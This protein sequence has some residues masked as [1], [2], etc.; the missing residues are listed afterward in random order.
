MIGSRKSRRT[1]SLRARVTVLLAT[2]VSLAVGGA[3]TVIDMR[4]DADMQQR[5]DSALLA[6]AQALT[7]LVRHDGRKVDVNADN[8]QTFTFPGNSSTHWYSL[9]CGDAVVART[10]Q[11]PPPLHAG[12]TPRFADARLTDGRRLRVVVLRFQPD[13]DAT[14]G[15][16]TA[17]PACVLRYGLDRKMLDEILYQ[18]D[19]ILV[20]SLLGACLVVLLATPW[21]VRRGLQPL[22]SLDAAMA[23]IG[24]DAPGKRLPDSTTSELDPLVARFNEVL[25]RMDA[26][27]TRERRFASGLAHEFRT[28]LAELRMLV[29][30]EQA[31]PSGRDVGSVLGEVGNIGAE[32][33]ATVTALLRLTRIES[34]LEQPRFEDTDPAMLL[35]R[36]IER[37]RE[38]AH[39]REVS[40]VIETA[41]GPPTRIATDPTLLDIVLDNLL[42]NAT[43]YAPANT[44][45]RV[46]VSSGAVTMSNAAPTLS[47]HDID[48]FGRRFWRK[49]SDSAGHAGL[50]LALAVAAAH[51]LKMSVAFALDNGVLRATLRWQPPDGAAHA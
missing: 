10:A 47:A 28:R 37:Q 40:I 45:I 17:A 30:V 42:G 16:D 38:P 26:G 34:G 24:P 6:R 19:M 51:V 2:A 1:F 32:L 29:D 14:P 31:H 49:D 3:A 4:A 15:P 27:L 44:Q 25:A 5:F 39:R 22:T 46:R 9:N 43:A 20:G 21:L 23:G 41:D 35:D 48:Q 18:L 50:G 13:L 12:P 8:A 11:V 33:E 7:A 36:A